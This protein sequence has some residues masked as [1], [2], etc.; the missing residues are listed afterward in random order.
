ME[1]R[2]TTGIDTR[3]SSLEKEVRAHLNSVTSGTTT[4]GVRSRGLPGV[5]AP[6][7]KFSAHSVGQSLVSLAKSALT[8]KQSSREV[9]P[10][11]MKIES[12][13][14]EDR[15]RG[16][17]MQVEDRFM[18]LEANVND[19]FARLFSLVQLA[20][21]GAHSVPQPSGMSEAPVQAP[22][23]ALP[24]ASAQIPI[25]STQ[26]RPAVANDLD[27]QMKAFDNDDDVDGLTSEA[28][29]SERGVNNEQSPATEDMAK[30]IENE[31]KQFDDDE[32]A[33]NADHQERRFEDYENSNQ[34]GEN[35]DGEPEEQQPQEY[36][37]NYDDDN[38]N[39]D[40]EDGPGIEEP[41]YPRNSSNYQDHSY[42]DGQGYQSNPYGNT[43]G[44]GYNPSYQQPHYEAENEGYGT[45]TYHNI[46]SGYQ[47]QSFGQESGDDF[48]DEDPQDYNAPGYDGY[49][50]EGY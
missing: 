35:T 30:E 38:P 23:R 28:G 21:S 31:M 8:P 22:I 15:L 2:L 33:S 6:E 49:E 10:A 48:N 29:N 12:V 41:G 3:V 1:E 37:D 27:D 20:V 11:S 44:F 7:E 42:D 46:N 47:Q 32:G 26:Q 5:S 4:D 40:D 25:S 39:Y 19:N 14:F 9:V 13:H 34:Q 50:S 45:R 36:G 16:L 43:Q 24:P 18:K 17:E